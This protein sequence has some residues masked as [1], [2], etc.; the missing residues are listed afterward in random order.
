MAMPR[1]SRQI[2]WASGA[3]GFTLLEI[4]IALSLLA[5]LAAFAWPN[6]QGQITTSELPQSAEQLRS[7]IYMTRS[8]AVMEHRRFRIRFTPGE[9]QPIIEWEPDPIQAP[10]EWEPSKS[11]WATEPVLLSDVQVH[12]V[13]AGRPEWT[14]PISSTG[15]DEQ[16][17]AK[18][19]KRRQEQS[20]EEKIQEQKFMRGALISSDGSGDDDEYRPMIIFGSDGSTEWATFVLARLDPEEELTEEMEQIWVLLDGRTGLATIRGQI[21]EE[22]LS[23]PNFYVAREKLDLPDTADIEDLTFQLDQ[24]TGSGA[25]QAGGTTG[26]GNQQ[27]L[28]SQGLQAVGGQTNLQGG[29]GMPTA[30]NEGD[31]K[32]GDSGTQGGGHDGATPSGGKQDGKSGGSPAAG[33]DAGGSKSGEDVNDPDMT[34]EEKENMRHWVQGN[35]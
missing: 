19:E 5:M 11:A 13:T 9:Q 28:L 24:G 7:A 23:D 17:A 1:S 35:R 16:E 25:E 15:P 6:L 22:Q 3:R 18:Q 12:R 10:G 4:M 30:D 27:D 14:W 20:D 21:T 31:E 2:R 33:N 8:D 29:Q 34:E 32:P 26:M